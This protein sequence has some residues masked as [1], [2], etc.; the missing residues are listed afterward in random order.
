MASKYI[1]L[2]QILLQ[3]NIDNIFINILPLMHKIEADIGIINNSKGS[4]MFKCANTTVICTVDINNRHEQSKSELYDQLNLDI[5]YR[6]INQ[7]SYD[8]YYTLIITNILN[9]CLLNFDKCKSLF[10]SLIIDSNNYNTLWCAINAL[11]LGLVEC[12][13]PLK[14]VLYATSGFT[15]KEDVFIFNRSGDIVWH[16]AFGDIK[17]IEMPAVLKFYKYV[18]EI[19]DFSFKSKLVI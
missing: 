9:R 5:K 19:Q 6:N 17:D 15:N 1:L 10:I 16:H 18:K 8:V 3:S 2:L 11:F 4:S 14:E 13:V 12:G 7:Q